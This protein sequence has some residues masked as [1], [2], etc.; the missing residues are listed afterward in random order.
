[1]KVYQGI[2]LEM[3]NQRMNSNWKEMNKIKGYEM[4]VGLNSTPINT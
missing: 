2:Y 3:G 4:L 1:M